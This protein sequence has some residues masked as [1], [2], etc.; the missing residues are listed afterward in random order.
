MGKWSFF[1]KA[2]LLKKNFKGEIIPTGVGIIFILAGTLTWGLYRFS[3]STFNIGLDRLL[4]LSIVTGLVGFVDDLAGDKENQ[5]LIGHFGQLLKGKITTGLF[6]VVIIGLAALLAVKGLLNIFLVI[7]MTNFVNLLDL[8]PGRAVK[9]FLLISLLVLMLIPTTYIIFLP[10]YVVTIIYLFY[11][12]KGKAMLGDTGANYLGVILG[13]SLTLLPFTLLK[14]GISIIL[15][16][17][18]LLS[19]FYSFTEI[20]AGNRFLKWFDQLGR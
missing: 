16:L 11:E 3:F 18:T 2:G 1:K 10:I 5:G 14:A 19:E 13:F 7:L 17:L 8:R 15:F 4:F 6:K 12:L 9:F 20:I